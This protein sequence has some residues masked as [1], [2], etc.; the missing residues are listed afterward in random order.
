MGS[1]PLMPATL[2]NGHPTSI[3]IT[4]MSYDKLEEEYQAELERAY[5]LMDRGVP[6][7]ELGKAFDEIVQLH[8]PRPVQ[9]GATDEEIDDPSPTTGLA[10]PPL[11]YTGLPSHG[12]P[13]AEITIAVLCSPRSTNC[14]PPLDTAKR[15]A[16]T[17]PDEVRVVWAPYFDIERD[18]AADLSLR[19]DAALCAERDGGRSVD[20][21]D[22]WD[23]Q[24]SPGWRWVWEALGQAGLR[25][26][27]SPEDSIDRVAT[28][29]RVEPRAFATCRAQL[30]GS[31]IT[32]IEAA[33]RAGVRTTP[34]TI[35]NGRIYG[36]INDF[37]TLQELVEAELAPGLLAPAWSQPD[38]VDD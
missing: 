27:L 13:H 7:S 31:S 29:L 2:V 38:L 36:P 12:S 24:D 32:W 8:P 34:A 30:A 10:D 9:S 5:D 19:A 16:D 3:A 14:L 22:V 17:Y 18:D 26:N 21:D 25:R 11:D 37:T 6:R 35:V 23:P 33:R 20:R 15:I 1:N 4:S 28:K